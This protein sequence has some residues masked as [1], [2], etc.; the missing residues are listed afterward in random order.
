[1]PLQRCC[2]WARTMVPARVAYEVAFAIGH[3][4]S[5][6][7]IVGGLLNDNAALVRIGV[8]LNRCAF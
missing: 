3:L 5:T 2:G 4:Y 6:T 8:L 7:W 1:M